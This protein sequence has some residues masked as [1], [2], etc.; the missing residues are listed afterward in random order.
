[1]QAPSVYQQAILHH[2]KNQ[3]NSGVIEN[4]DLKASVVNPLCGDELT[5]FMTLNQHEISDCK[6]HVRGCS[7]CI[8]SASIMSQLIMN[9]ELPEAHSISYMLVENLKNSS[10]SIEIEHE[11]LLPLL[12]IKKHKSRIKCVRL[13]WDAL[14]K[15]HSQ[16]VEAETAD[17]NKN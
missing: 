4:P 16:F 11:S 8:A 17:S 13:P 2:A 15:C 3:K 14:E 10:D 12:E 1:M 6:V 7:L 5:V 9:M